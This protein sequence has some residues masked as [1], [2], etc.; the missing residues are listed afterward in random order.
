ML[1]NSQHPHEKYSRSLTSAEEKFPERSLPEQRSL[2]I[3]LEVVLADMALMDRVAVFRPN[4]G[5]VESHAVVVSGHVL[6]TVPPPFVKELHHLPRRHVLPHTLRLLVPRTDPEV[7]ADDVLFEVA[8]LLLSGRE[9]WEGLWVVRLAAGG[10]GVEAADHAEG[11]LLVGDGRVVAHDEA[12]R[13]DWLVGPGRPS[14]LGDFRQSAAA[15]ICRH[16]CLHRGS[17]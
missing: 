17:I 13:K 16:G 14:M 8:D 15:T 2:A 10:D 3:G 5:A 6:L 1:Y 11:A 12:F 9:G 7:V 4:A